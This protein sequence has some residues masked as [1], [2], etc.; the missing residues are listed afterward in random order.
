VEMGMNHAGEIARLTAIAEPSAGL[1]TTVQ[2]AHLK[3]LGSLEGVAAAKGELFAGLAQGA[4]AV[5]NLD[6]PLILEQA[7][8]SGAN[9]LTFGRPDAAD[10]QLQRVE[11]RGR[12][13]LR[14]VIRADGKG[15]V[16]RL[17]FVGE[18]NAHN[19]CA[20]FALATAM[21]FSPEECVQGL[22]LARPYA[23]RLN[24][25]EGPRGLIIVD[26][27]YNA[28]PASMDAA[29]ATL[30]QLAKNGRTVAVLGDMLELGN[31]EAAAHRRLGERAKEVAQLAAFFGPRSAQAHASAAMGERSA[32][33]TE[34][35]P[36][37]AW[38]KPQLLP[39]DVVLVKASRGMK[40]ERVVDNLMGRPTGEGH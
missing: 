33:F 23:R 9:A 19:A 1:I 18:H 30:A 15:H 38:L 32:H 34:V 12:E 13:G 5:V 27:C 29:L 26:D 14:L 31:E 25:L 35:E 17:S 22:E 28:N 11:E 20:A 16:V 8:K 36:L 10:V 3:G 37:I 7:R 2:A 24:V 4:R 6:E 39:G 40:L 21:G